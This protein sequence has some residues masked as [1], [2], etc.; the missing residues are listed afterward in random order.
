[1][2]CL[3]VVL[4]VQAHG[5]D[6]VAKV[7]ATLAGKKLRFSE[8]GVAEG[9]KTT[10]ALLESCHNRSEGAEDDIKKA[11]QGD[12]VRLVFAKP[13]GSVSWARSWRCRSWCRPSP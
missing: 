4:A 13:V 8:K 12:R 7:S 11:L 3:I 9:V 6:E 2:R 1:M 5:G 10:T